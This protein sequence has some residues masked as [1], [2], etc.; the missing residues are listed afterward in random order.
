MI[1]WQMATAKMV[2]N[3]FPNNY[4]MQCELRGSSMF[5]SVR[6][7]LRREDFGSQTKNKRKYLKRLRKKERDCVC[8][9][10]FLQSQSPALE[11]PK[12]I[13]I[14]NSQTRPNSTGPHDSKTRSLSARRLC[15]KLWF[16]ERKLRPSPIIPV[17]LLIKEIIEKNQKL[18]LLCT[19]F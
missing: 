12:V 8:L 18:H 17:N 4:S 10:P 6:C 5:Y 11:S 15:R 13:R 9:V 3:T 2:G 1:N 14:R 16:L 19:R 7:P